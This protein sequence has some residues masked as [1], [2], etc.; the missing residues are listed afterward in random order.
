MKKEVLL[1]LYWVIG[2]G[3]V[4]V[5][6]NVCFGAENVSTAKDVVRV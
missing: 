2:F 4:L 1:F 6:I 3:A 5:L